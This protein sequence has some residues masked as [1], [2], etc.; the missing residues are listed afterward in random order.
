[1]VDVSQKPDTARTA[2]A[3]GFVLMNRETLAA[4]K[5]DSIAKGDVLSCA[6]IAGIMAAKQTSNLIPLCHPLPL[7]NVELTCSFVSPDENTHLAPK[8]CP[9]KAYGIH[10]QSK[11]STTGKTGVEME[12][13]S[14]VSVA[15][16]A[17]YDMCKAL[18]KGMEIQNVRL[19][20]K[21]GGKSGTWLREQ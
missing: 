13:L 14:A 11:C 16:L 1:M 7:T 4:V 18:D 12:A 3:E 8:G 19:L 21:E 17:V 20:R 15:C 2:V 9:R 5:T 6:R 10:V